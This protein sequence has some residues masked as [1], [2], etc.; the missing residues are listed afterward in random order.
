MILFCLHNLEKLVWKSPYLRGKCFTKVLHVQSNYYLQ[1]LELRSEEE[2]KVSVFFYNQDNSCLI[3]SQVMWD[4]SGFFYRVLLW[5]K[6]DSYFYF[7]KLKVFLFNTHH[8]K[9][10]VIMFTRS[11]I[12]WAIISGFGRPPLQNSNM[13]GN[14]WES[15]GRRGSDVIQSRQRKQFGYLVWASEFLK[16]FCS[17]FFTNTIEIRTDLVR[18]WQDYAS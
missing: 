14:N 9:L 7:H 17:C 15:W 13:A 11:V 1:V 16:G 8:A 10:Q 2:N 3:W 6:I 5:S 18:A 12:N 4:E